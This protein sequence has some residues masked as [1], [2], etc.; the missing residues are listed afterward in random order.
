MYT[1]LTNYC[2]QSAFLY[3]Q[4]YRTTL[5]HVKKLQSDNEHGLITISPDLQESR[6]DTQNSVSLNNLAGK[7]F[8]YEYD[9]QIVMGLPDAG[10][11]FSVNR[12]NAR[13][14]ITFPDDFRYNKIAYMQ[15]RQPK[16]YKSQTMV[17]KPKCLL[18]RQKMEEVNLRPELAKALETPVK[19]VYDNN[20]YLFVCYTVFF[21]D[22]H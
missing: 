16:S 2:K 9:G 7:Q 4:K 1:S 8:N 15:M 19:F 22:K 18:P 10:R 5:K 11:Q 3:I 12:L 21:I 6:V 13:I 14:S 20:M 17:K